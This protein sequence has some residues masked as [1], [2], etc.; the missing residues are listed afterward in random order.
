MC[1]RPSFVSLVSYHSR[2]SF[3]VHLSVISLSVGAWVR[4]CVG[5]WVCRRWGGWGGCTVHTARAPLLLLCHRAEQTIKVSCVYLPVSLLFSCLSF[6]FCFY[7]ST[8]SIFLFF[9]FL[10]FLLFL[11]SHLSHSFL[12]YFLHFCIFVHF[13][14]HF[15]FHRPHF[16][17]PL[18]LPSLLLPR[19]SF[20][21]SLASPLYPTL[22]S[23]HSLPPS[24]P[25]HQK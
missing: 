8:K 21:T 16:S 20:L 3:F 15:I 2:H 1:E 14:S 6:P 11:H 24:V 7:F 18:T 19:P 25:K 10:L 12:F 23:P 13:Q 4:G 22:P 17:R 9:P 5:V